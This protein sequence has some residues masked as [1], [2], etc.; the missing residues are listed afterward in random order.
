[1]LSLKIN[2][3]LDCS[4]SQTRFLD[5]ESCLNVFGP[6][7][8]VPRVEIVQKSLFRPRLIFIG[9]QWTNGV[10]RCIGPG[11]VFS[12]SDYPRTIVTPHTWYACRQ[13]SFDPVTDKHTHNHLFRKTLLSVEGIE[14]KETSQTSDSTSPRLKTPWEPHFGEIRVYRLPSNHCHPRKT[15]SGFELP[16]WNYP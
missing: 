11:F 4:Q 12:T 6:R 10:S 16:T 13:C 1:M 15:D 5:H 2:F 8:R 3:A 9:S 14:R 7:I